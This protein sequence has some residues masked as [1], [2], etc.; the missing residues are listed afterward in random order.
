MSAIGEMG[1]SG[2]SPDALHWAGAWNARDKDNKPYAAVWIIPTSPGGKPVTK[3][4]EPG[5]TVS[6]L[7][8]ADSQTLRAL[9]TRTSSQ[10]RLLDSRLISFGISNPDES[11]ALKLADGISSILAWPAGSD[12]MLTRTNSPGVVLAILTSKAE[13]VGKPVV[14]NIDSDSDLGSLSAISPDGRL[15][16]FSVVQ[17]ALGGSLAFYLGN[18]ADGTSKL[19]FTTDDLPGRVEHLS[20]SPVGVLLVTAVRSD[21]ETFLYPWDT[22]RLQKPSER[23]DIDMAAAWPDAPKSLDLLTY[24]GAFNYAPLTGKTKP[25]FGFGATDRLTESWRREAQDG[26]LYLAGEYYVSISLTAGA[27]DVRRVTRDGK[28]QTPILPRRQQ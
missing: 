22:S 28:D 26:R 21:F 23:T 18:T 4:M 2:I 25:I 19:L 8:W 9:L 5:Y 14:V 17:T 15:F 6:A 24:E 11:T 3:R 10:G 7:F 16:L 20:V 1:P 12:A 27:A 13:T